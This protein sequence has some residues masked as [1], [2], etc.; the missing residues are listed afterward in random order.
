MR[1]NV[2]LAPL[3]CEA[4]V[5]LLAPLVA[6]VRLPAPDEVDLPVYVISSVCNLIVPYIGRLSV[7]VT[8]IV[9]VDAS[10]PLLIVVILLI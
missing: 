10:I 3:K 8:G 1:T 9:V 4:A 6:P 2:R 7:A 5:V